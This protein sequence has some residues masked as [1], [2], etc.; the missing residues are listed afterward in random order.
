MAERA[1]CVRGEHQLIAPPE[2]SQRRTR[3]LA[4]LDLALSECEF[5]AG[6]KC[7]QWC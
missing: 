3:S 7:T 5:R 2:G 6:Q 1:V 4:L